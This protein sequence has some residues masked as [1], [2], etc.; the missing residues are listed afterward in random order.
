MT[1][2]LLVMAP[3]K[4]ILN[5][6][7][8]E[9]ILPSQTGQLG[10]LK[11]HT[12]LITVL[13]IGVLKIKVEE[14]WIPIVLLGGFATI[15]NNSVIVLVSDAETIIPGKYEDAISSL[16]QANIEYENLKLMTIESEQVKKIE[17]EQLKQAGLESEQVKE[18]ELEQLK[19]IEDNKEILFKAG[20]MIKYASAIVEA[21]K[22]M[23]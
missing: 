13:A 17:L 3:G 5:K 6:E 2:H 7:V 15:T 23:S 20:Q 18:I 21:Y 19:L 12:P 8:D 16:K 1:V 11:G 22:Y 10:V 4:E 14:K 9:I